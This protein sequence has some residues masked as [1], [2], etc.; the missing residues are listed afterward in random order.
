MGGIPETGFGGL[1]TDCDPKNMGSCLSDSQA[2][3]M[4]EPVPEMNLLS[5]L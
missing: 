1:R 3:G 2:S 5:W 4:A